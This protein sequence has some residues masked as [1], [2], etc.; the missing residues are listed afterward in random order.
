MLIKRANQLTGLQILLVQGVTQ[1]YFLLSFML[2][3]PPFAFP[4]TGYKS[5]YQ[6]GRKSKKISFRLPVV[7]GGFDGISTE[8]QLTSASNLQVK[9]VISAALNGNAK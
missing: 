9:S 2:S 4:I 5:T 6:L 3:L 8:E 7:R 1:T